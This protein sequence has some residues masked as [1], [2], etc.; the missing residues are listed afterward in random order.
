M[1]LIRSQHYKRINWYQLIDLMPRTLQFMESI[2]RLPRAIADQLQV[3][4]KIAYEGVRDERY[5][6][7]DVVNCSELRLFII[8]MMKRKRIRLSN[9]TDDDPTF[10]S[11]LLFSTSLCRSIC[12][13][14]TFH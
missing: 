3:I 14:Y 9:H 10:T 13:L 5:E 11:G 4:A 1:G 2:N 7:T 8:G 12:Q 6:F